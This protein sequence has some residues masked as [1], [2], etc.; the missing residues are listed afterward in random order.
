MLV[1]GIIETVYRE[2]PWLDGVGGALRL[3]AD[4]A[5]K[6]LVSNRMLPV[7]TKK[8]SVYFLA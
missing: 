5:L 6:T 2:G 3:L 7:D 4:I 1:L 8:D